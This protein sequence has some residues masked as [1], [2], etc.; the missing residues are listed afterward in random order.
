[1]KE[2]LHAK[3]TVTS[4]LHDTLIPGEP[5]PERNLARIERIQ[6]RLDAADYE[7]RFADLF[8]LIGGLLTF[9][10]TAVLAFS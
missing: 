5:T 1:M 7:A 10:G 4:S 8:V 3:A 9:A 2:S 6:I